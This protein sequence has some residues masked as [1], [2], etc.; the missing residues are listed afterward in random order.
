MVNQPNRNSN[1][2]RDNPHSNPLVFQE[3]T[4]LENPQEI[5]ETCFEYDNPPDFDEFQN[6]PTYDNINIKNGGGNFSS[7]S[8]GG[9]VS[10]L[11]TTIHLHIKPRNFVINR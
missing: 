4:H 7:T 2:W 6:D 10:C 1:Y 5:Q 3:I 11:S 9:T 8:L